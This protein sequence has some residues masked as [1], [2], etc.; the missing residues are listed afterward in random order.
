MKAKQQSSKSK[1]PQYK[2][3]VCNYCEDHRNLFIS[4]GV[5][6]HNFKQSNGLDYDNVVY[7]CFYQTA[8]GMALYRRQS[9]AFATE[10]VIAARGKLNI[11]ESNVK[12]IKQAPD[13]DSIALALERVKS[14]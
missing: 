13:V 14:L 8:R 7:P 9:L 5:R 2:E 3:D 4:D 10:R 6:Y 1:P 11:L 12:R